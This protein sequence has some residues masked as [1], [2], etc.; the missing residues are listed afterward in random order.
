MQ[1]VKKLQ[2]CN[3]RPVAVENSALHMRLGLVLS[4]ITGVLFYVPGVQAQS[5]GVARNYCWAPAQLR[6][7]RGEAKVGITRRAYRSVPAGGIIRATAQ[8]ES[9]GKVLRR[10]ELPPG[11]KLVAFTFDLCEQPFEF[12]GYQ[13]DI[14]DYLREHKVPATFF[15]GGKW[16]LTHPERA[17]QLLGNPLFEVANHVWEHHYFPLLNRARMDTETGAG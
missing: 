16:L 5:N 7:K 12:A 3:P 9:T 14:I 2:V 10:V 11:R 17:A 15:A 8:F 4:L 1:V 13:G 6:A